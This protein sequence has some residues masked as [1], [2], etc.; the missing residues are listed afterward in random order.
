MSLYSEA[1]RCWD[2]MQNLLDIPGNKKQLRQS[3]HSCN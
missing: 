1:C 3:F 2:T